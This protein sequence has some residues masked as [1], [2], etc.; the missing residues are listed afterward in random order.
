MGINK[1]FAMLQTLPALSANLVK[2]RWC[3]SEPL[4][5]N[6]YCFNVGKGSINRRTE[7]KDHVH[8]GCKTDKQNVKLSILKNMKNNPS[9]YHLFIIYYCMYKFEK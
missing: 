7:W 8:R 3:K 5:L 1:F 9:C 4:V 2:Y 6:Q